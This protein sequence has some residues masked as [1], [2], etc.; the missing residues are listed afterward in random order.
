MDE[1]GVNGVKITPDILIAAAGG[2]QGA[3][4]LLSTWLAQA[5]A[6]G[7][8]ENKKETRSIL[9]NEVMQTP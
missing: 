9:G 7:L 6:K 4:S 8:I 2:D 3:T 1:V 5:V